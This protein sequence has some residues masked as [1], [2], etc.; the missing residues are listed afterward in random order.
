MG[1]RQPD[2]N[3]LKLIA[4]AFRY[5]HL[6]ITG[7]GDSLS[8]IAEKEGVTT[9]YFTRVLRISLVDTATIESILLGN[10]GMTISKLLSEAS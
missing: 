5:Q 3:V 10:Q 8:A 6:L 9:S 4:K 1:S 7:N 2:A